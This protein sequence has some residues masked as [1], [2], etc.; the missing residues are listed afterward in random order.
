VLLTMTSR[1]DKL[2]PEPRWVELGR[3][4]AMPVVLPWGSDEERARAGRIGRG[5]GQ[6]IVPDRMTLPQLGGVFVNARAVVGLD[7]GLT[8]VAAAL[9]VPTVGVYCGSDPA[10]T[11]LYGA[12][13]ARNVGAAGRPPEV[14]EVLQS[15][16]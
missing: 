5:I 11:G 9:G 13:R 3:A 2:W 16:A 6:A 7:T 8:H 12:A 1:A 4:L 10:L 15:L 14:S